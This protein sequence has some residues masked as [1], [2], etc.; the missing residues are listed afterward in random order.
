M[1]ERLKIIIAEATAKIFVMPQYDAEEP[2]DQEQQKK[3]K[4]YE[5]KVEYYIKGAMTR[6]P[7]EQENRELKAEI[8]RLKQDLKSASKK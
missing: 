2:S 6:I 5:I 8:K 1:N 7:I 3:M 4:E